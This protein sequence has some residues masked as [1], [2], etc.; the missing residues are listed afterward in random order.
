MADVP[1]EGVAKFMFPAALFPPISILKNPL[2][3]QSRAQE[4]RTNQ[5]F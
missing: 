1:R 4:L 2:A 3:A 5:Y